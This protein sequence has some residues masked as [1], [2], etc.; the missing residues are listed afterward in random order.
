MREAQ[1]VT[2]QSVE[3]TTNLDH[4]ASLSTSNALIGP[5]ASGNAVRVAASIRLRP[6][7]SNARSGV[8]STPPCHRVRGQAADAETPANQTEAIARHWQLPSRTTKYP[9]ARAGGC[10]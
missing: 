2:E 5:P 8:T 1:E 9:L 7:P 3:I 4:C 10:I 6:G